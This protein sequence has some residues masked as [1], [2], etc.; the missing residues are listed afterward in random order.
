MQIISNLDHCIFHNHPIFVFIIFICRKC[1]PQLIDLSYDQPSEHSRLMKQ[2]KI[3]FRK[4]LYRPFQPS[5]TLAAEI[6]I[7]RGDIGRFFSSYS[8]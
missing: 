3:D 6:E 5:C 1:T 7:P 8:V 2:P 4:D